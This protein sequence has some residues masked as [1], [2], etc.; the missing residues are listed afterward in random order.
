MSSIYAHIIVN[1]VAG[2]GKTAREWPHIK[3]LFRDRGLRFEHALT[4]GPGHAVELARAAVSRGYETVV[5]VGGDGTINEIV[6]GLHQSGGMTETALGVISTGT[7][8]NSISDNCHERMNARAIAD[9]SISG[10]SRIVVNSTI[11]AFCETATSFV[12]RDTNSPDRRRS[13]KLIDKVIR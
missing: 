12:N 5:S 6:N 3:N 4:E 8:T 2:A 1:P 11:M 10:W 7:T 9:T 13:K